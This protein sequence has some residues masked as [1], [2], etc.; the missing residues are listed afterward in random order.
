MRPVDPIERVGLNT[1]DIP[2]MKLNADGSVDI[3]IGPKAPKGWESNWIPTQGKRPFPMMRIYG[4]E[5]AFWDKSFK[6][7]DLELVE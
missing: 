5:E 1:Y 3:Y 7:P 6:L 4:G 2:N